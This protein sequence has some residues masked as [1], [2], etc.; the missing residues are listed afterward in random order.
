MKERS[1]KST[2]EKENA[3]K[4]RVL[5]QKNGNGFWNLYQELIRILYGAERAS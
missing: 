5:L 2:H 1:L 4:L 3:N